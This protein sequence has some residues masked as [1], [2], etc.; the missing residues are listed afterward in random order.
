[1]SLARTIRRKLEQAVLS[2]DMTTIKGLLPLIEKALN[3]PNNLVLCSDAYKYSHYKFYPDKTQVVHSYLESRGGKFDKT[4]FYGL[5]IYLREFLEGIAITAEDVNEAYEYLGDKLG[6]FGRDDVFDRTKFDYIV[7]KHG[8]RLPIRICAVPEGAVVDTKNVLMTIENTDPN[9]AWLTNFLETILLQVWY[10]ITVA[11][12]SREIKK[13]A[14]KY[15]QKTT[16]YD[17]ATI[18]FLVKFVLNDFGFRGVSSVQSARNGGSAH[19]VNFDGSDT[20]V[21][22]LV[23]NDIYHSKIRGLSIPATEHSIMTILGEEGEVEMMKRTLQQFPTGLVACVSDSFNIFRAC[24]DYWGGELKEMILS[25]PAEP[26]NQ[27]VIRPDSGDPAMTLKEVFKILFD[28]FGYT[29]NSKGYKVLPPQVRVIQ[30]DGVNINSI[31]KI[32]AMLDELKISAENL[33]FGMGGKLLQADI[34]RDTQNF[35]T[36]ASF[37]I[38]DGVEHDV[39]KS[40]TEIDEHGNFIKSFKK[41]KSGRLK[42]VKTADGYRTVTSKD[43]DFN[44]ALDELIP[45]F[46]NGTIL[47]EHTFEEV[48]ERAAV[49][50]EELETVKEVY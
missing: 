16:D 17:A 28:K 49:R 25:R 6:V 1:M 41:S 7:E 26:G 2:N 15:F 4:V 21:A 14:I 45:V 24:A 22:N 8:G 33:V 12:L 50:V 31:A 35:A 44:L 43:A 9:C 30:G 13:I 20:V 11:T 23:I 48:R 46:E 38:I 34:N 19:L 40:P 36:K 27:L 18:E 29:T 42:L 10:P 39:I 47:K 3:R 5:Q 37:V 32:Y